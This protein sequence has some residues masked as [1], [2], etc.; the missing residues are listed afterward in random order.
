MIFP[1][2]EITNVVDGLFD[3]FFCANRVAQVNL[4]DTLTES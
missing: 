1:F 3:V 2:A 4:N